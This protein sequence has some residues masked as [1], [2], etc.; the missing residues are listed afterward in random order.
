MCV[1]REGDGT[2]DAEAGG[3]GL[4]ED[5]DDG[6][7]ECAAG[8]EVT[9]ILS[10]D[11]SPCFCLSDTSPWFCLSDTSPWFCLLYDNRRL[12][13]GPHCPLMLRKYLHLRTFTRLADCR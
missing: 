6:E 12:I 5:S 10:T 8:K 13:T 3:A 4:D 2:V 1:G 9:S 11:T 7:S